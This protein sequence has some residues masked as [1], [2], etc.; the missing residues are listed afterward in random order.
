MTTVLWVSTSPASWVGR[1]RRG[2]L[3]T[4]DSSSW[5]A[6]SRENHN[7][8]LFQVMDHNSTDGGLDRD[9]FALP[10]LTLSSRDPI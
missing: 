7:E 4:P 5:V 2:K 8:V 6:G 10:T 1:A 3:T 9:L